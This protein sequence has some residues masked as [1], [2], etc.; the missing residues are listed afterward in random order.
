MYF[1][2]Q[3]ECRLS[4]GPMSVSK[5][6]ART[7][8][9]H[10]GFE[11]LGIFGFFL[12]VVIILALENFTLHVEFF[13][14]TFE[15]LIWVRS[16]TTPRKL[17][18]IGIKKRASLEN[19]KCTANDKQGQSPIFQNVRIKISGRFCRLLLN[20]PRDKQTSQTLHTKIFMSYLQ[21][22]K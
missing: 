17:L 11:C 14:S 3:N 19:K 9:D 12:V 2:S 13:S 4:N 22:S 1:C 20:Y 7:F 8:H 15:R 5:I 16:F 18:N 10:A 21:T 6:V